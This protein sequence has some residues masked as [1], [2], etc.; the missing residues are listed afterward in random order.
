MNDMK[1]GSVSLSLLNPS[2]FHARHF[3]SLPL[4]SYAVI[5]SSWCSLYNLPPINS[6]STEIYASFPSDL[7]LLL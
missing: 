2:T 7:A 3:M 4:I 1:S 5:G 6:L